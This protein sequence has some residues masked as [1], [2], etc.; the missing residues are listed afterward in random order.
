ME[1]DRIFAYINLDEKELS[2]YEILWNYLS[3]EVS[4]PDLIVYLQ[5]KTEVLM[6]RISKRGRS[7]ESNMDIDYIEKLNQAYNYFFFHYDDTN[8]IAVKTDDI[9]F[10]ENPE[11]LDL[12][13]DEIDLF[14]GGKKYIDPL[15]L[16][17]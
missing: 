16:M 17:K 3:R 7:F 8:L 6:D 4:K 1:K 14:K 15:K 13:L 5:A 10:V 11:H 2:L 9:D 12:I